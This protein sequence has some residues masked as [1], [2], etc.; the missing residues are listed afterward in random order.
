MTLSEIIS[1]ALTELGRGHD[2]RSVDNYKLKFTR[3]ANDALCDIATSFRLMRSEDVRISGSTIDILDFE[4]P[5]LK[6]CA[7]TQD[8]HMLHY[9]FND[10]SGIAC[11][12]GTG[13]C[14]AV[15]RYV[16]K[17]LSLPSDVPEIPEF[18]HGLIVC[19]VTGRE[20]MSGDTST[21]RGADAYLGLY[22]AEKSRL[23]AAYC[24][25]DSIENK[26]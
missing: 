2:A 3:Y 6:L 18:M 24:S 14:K 25:S 4:R 20:R 12:R 23:L 16:P 13:L 7:I 5:C 8:G 21:Q 19:Y 22:E 26:W 15:Y 11:V 17:K 10:A 9:T 1:A